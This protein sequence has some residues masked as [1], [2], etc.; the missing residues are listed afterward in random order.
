MRGVVLGLAGRCKGTF[1]KND[2]EGKPAHCLSAAVCVCFGCESL[3]L[4][5]ALLQVFERVSKHVDIYRLKGRGIYLRE[6]FITDRS[7]SESAEKKK[8]VII[9]AEERYV[10]HTPLVKMEFKHSIE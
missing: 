4:A 8:S 5:G 10:Y 6:A 3:G 9:E 7:T 1:W 2:D